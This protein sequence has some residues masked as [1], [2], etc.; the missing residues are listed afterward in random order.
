[1]KGNIETVVIGAGGYVGGELLRLI[2]THPKLELKAAV[3]ESRAASPIGGT[4]PALAYHFTCAPFVS[5]EHA[6][7]QV[8]DGA[9]VA[10]FSAAPHAA[11]A[12]SVAGFLAATEHR[13]HE[14]HVVD[15]SA[16]FRFAS[17]NDFEA[18]YGERHGA[19]EL[20]ERFSCALP[21]HLSE[22]PK[23]CVGH[24]GCFA[25]AVLLATV[26]L[27]AANLVAGAVHVSAVT[28]STG[29]GRE[30]KEGTH[31]PERHGNFYAYK[32]LGHRHVPEIEALTAQACGRSVRVNF[33]PHSGP[34]ARGIYVT[35]H[36]PL[37]TRLNSAELLDMY[38]AYYPD[39]PFIH[40]QP[41]VPKL[42][43][44]V[45]SNRAHLGVAVDGDHAVVMCA[46]DNLMK[47]AAGG[48]VQW[49]NRL[50]GLPETDGLT[51]PSPAW[52]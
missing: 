27:V 6:I 25:T 8:S 17:A 43:D 34:F 41:T 2:A 18:V 26:P 38:R 4:F 40:V 35:L 13:V 45:T 22:A 29:S 20:L 11:S 36:A 28:G 23:S 14:V 33:V 49:M 46:I 30:P 44:V 24:P 50:F 32:P 47:G 48:A 21:E 39:S 12:R 52:T 16:D 3:S 10:V 31:H 1:M 42:K 5:A 51:V 9:S 7:K 19:P 37:S 15:C